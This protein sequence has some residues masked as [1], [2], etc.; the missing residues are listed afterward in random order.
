MTAKEVQAN[1][2][3]KE[4]ERKARIKAE[5]NKWKRFCKWCWFCFSFPWVWL[6]ENLRDWQTWLLFLIVLAI[7][8]GSVWGFYLAALLCGW[9][10]TEA[11]KW[12]IGVGSSVWAWWL[13][14]IGSP[15][16][17]LCVS[18][19]IGLKALI[20]KIKDGIHKRKLKKVQANER[21]NQT[22]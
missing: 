3:A 5:P 11:G 21:E 16:I 19:T 22:N 9:T 20:N 2:K 4:K 10:A 17:I 14:P 8:S 18:T 15:F 6:W 13:S 1:Y 12:L 7:Y